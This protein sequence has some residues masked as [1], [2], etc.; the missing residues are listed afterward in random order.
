MIGPFTR[1]LYRTVLDRDGFPWVLRLSEVGIEVR[2]KRRRAW[3]FRSWDALIQQLYKPAPRKRRRK[4]AGRGAPHAR[5]P[6][7][8]APFA[9]WDMLHGRKAGDS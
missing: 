8:A 5:K 6:D 1:D 4:R 7:R 9:V 3:R 2:A